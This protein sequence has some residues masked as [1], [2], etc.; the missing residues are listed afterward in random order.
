[1]SADWHEAV[2]NNFDGPNSAFPDP[3]YPAVRLG[4][5]EILPIEDGASLYREGTAMHHCVGTYSDEVQRGNLYIYS[6]RRNDERVAT[7][8]LG[9]HNGRA[10]LQQIR[11]PCNTEPPKA[12]VA[13]AVRWLHSQRPLPPSKA[14]EAT[15]G[16][17]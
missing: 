13:T 4:D 1:L 17:D 5:Y 7:L 8:A 2:A 15:L 3:W 16:T 14:I 11:G 9:R 12:I 10:C 6:I